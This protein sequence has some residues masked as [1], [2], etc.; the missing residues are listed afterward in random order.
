MYLNKKLTENVAKVIIYVYVTS[1]LNG[2]HSQCNKDIE[3]LLIYIATVETNKHIEFL[4]YFKNDN[5]FK[6]AI[7][8]DSELHSILSKMYYKGP[9]KEKIKELDLP[10]K[11][12]SQVSKNNCT[13]SKK[14]LDNLINVGGS[15]TR[16]EALFLEFCD[17]AFD[18][19]L[20]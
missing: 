2:K 6:I 14:E 5:N 12:M 17:K 8:A 13:R 3:E 9:L 19:F 20:D 16:R 10:D 18:K 7:S 1:S 4:N 15:F 11:E